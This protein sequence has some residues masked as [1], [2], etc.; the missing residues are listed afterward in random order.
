MQT[1]GGKEVKSYNIVP[2]QSELH[3][4]QLSPAHVR[5]L[6]EAALVVGMSPDL[7]PWLASWAKANPAKP[8]VW[9]HEG[10][11]NPHAWTD[12]RQVKGMASKLAVALGSHTGSK[13]SQT[14]ADKYL[15]EI[16]RVD[17]T[18]AALFASLPPDRRSFVAQHGNLE[19]FAR[20]YGLDLCGII[21]G[22]GGAES[23]DPSARHFSELLRTIRTKGVRVVVTDLGHNDAFARR[24]CEDSGLR[25]PLPLGFDYLEAPG[26]PGDSWCALMLLNGRKLHEALSTR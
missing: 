21:H 13:E 23:A 24:L 15:M 18:L 19:P 22:G 25:A 26:S 3:D 7:E 9:L 14:N 17:E 8:V 12:P 1:I 11:G 4:F 10:E 6:H 2:P 16:T 5:K 20:R